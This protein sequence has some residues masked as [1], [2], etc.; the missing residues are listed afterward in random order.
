[1]L[2]VSGLSQLDGTLDVENFSGD[3]LSVDDRFTIMDFGSVE[4]DFT[5][6]DYNG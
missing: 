5:A 1:M 2:T 6:F 3:N 4:G